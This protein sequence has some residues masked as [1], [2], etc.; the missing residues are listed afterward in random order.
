[1]SK[2]KPRATIVITRADA[3]TIEGLG[4]GNRES[5]TRDYGLR[6]GGLQDELGT[7]ASG[8]GWLEGGRWCSGPIALPRMHCIL[9]K[10]YGASSELSCVA[11]RCDELS[12]F[13]LVVCECQ[14]LC[15]LWLS[16]KIYTPLFPPPY[17]P[18]HPTPSQ[19]G[20][21]H[22]ATR[23]SIFYSHWACQSARLRNSCSFS[24]IFYT[25]FGWLHL[26]VID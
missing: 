19:P 11:L 18:C 17:R 26:N 9:M 10:I 6:T 4:I 23:P 8:L 1:M 14:S 22:P 5:G 25:L 2:S 24:Y 7:M 16:W 21:N 20:S 3:Y 12:W 15:S 13:E